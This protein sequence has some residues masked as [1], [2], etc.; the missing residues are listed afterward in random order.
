[1][2]IGLGLIV[3]MGLILL[4]NIVEARQNSKKYSPVYLAAVGDERSRLAAGAG[5]SHVAARLLAGRGLESGNGR[6]QLAKRRIQCGRHGLVGC[7]GMPAAGAPLLGKTNAFASG[8]GRPCTGANFGRLSGGQHRFFADTGGL[9]GLAETAVAASI[10]EILLTQ[11]IFISIALLGV[12]LYT[13]RSPRDTRQRLGLERPTRHQLL[14]G[15][16]WIMVLVFMQSVAGA[17]WLLLDSSQ[18]ELLEGISS[19][20][21]GNIDTLAEWLLLAAATGLGEELLFRGAVQPVLGLGFTSFL[22]AAAHV[23]YGI[24]P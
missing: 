24:T 13:R 11:A 19:E 6:S 5:V 18:A 22:F 14:V 9:A 4:A 16:G 15:L 7:A 20:L 8:L 12:G 2:P 21:F 23:Q 17:I 10:Y 3:F 1:M